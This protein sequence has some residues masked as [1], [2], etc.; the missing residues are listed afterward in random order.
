MSCRQKGSSVSSVITRT[1]TVQKKEEFAIPEFCKVYGNQTCAFFEAPL[2]WGGPIMC[3]AWG[4]T[5]Y[6]GGVWPGVACKKIGTRAGFSVYKWS[7]DGTLTT[8]PTQII[9][10]NNG[11]P[12]TADLAFTNG[13]YYT[14]EGLQGVAPTTGIAPVIADDAQ[15]T[16]I[17]DLSGRRVENPTKGIYIINGKKVVI[18]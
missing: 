5:N 7:Y 16:V 12:Q 8:R 10:S 18:K 14:K 13:G 9:F 15:P 11:S 2:S 17:Y 4:T 6:T 1:Y 3:W